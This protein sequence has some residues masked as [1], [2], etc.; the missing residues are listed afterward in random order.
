MMKK[1]EILEI[2]A[3]APYFASVVFFKPEDNKNSSI[4]NP[5]F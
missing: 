1:K 4:Q 5:I 2:T 3:V